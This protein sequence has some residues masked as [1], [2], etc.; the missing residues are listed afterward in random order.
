MDA[1]G[2]VKCYKCIELSFDSPLTFFDK[3]RGS[4]K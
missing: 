2:I 4:Q 1:E 3:R